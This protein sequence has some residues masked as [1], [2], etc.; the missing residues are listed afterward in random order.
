MSTRS[1]F[2]KNP[3]I[4][5]KKDLSLSSVLQNLQAYNVATGNAPPLQQH[6]PA[7][8]GETICCKRRRDPKPKPKPPPPRRQNR[9]IEEN[10]APM[11]HQDYIDRR[12]QLLISNFNYHSN[13]KEVCTSQNYQELTCDVLGKPGTSKSCLSLVQYDSD[14]STSSECEGKQ[15]LPN[16]GH[17]NESD[18]VK[19]RT[20]QR[21]PNP[22]EPVCVMCGKYGEYICNETDDDICSMECKADLLQALKVVKDPLSNQR[23]DVSSGPKCTLPMHD[24]GDTW[25]YER[26]C[27]SK[28]SSILSTYDCWKCRRPGHLA[29]DCLVMTSDFGPQ[30]SQFNTPRPSCIIQKVKCCKSTCQVT[31]IRD[32]LT[33]QYCFDKAFDKFYDMKGTGLSIISGSI[34][35][36]DHFDWHSMN[37]M[38]ANVE[39]SGYIISRNSQKGKRIQLSDFIF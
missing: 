13:L 32:L 24:F 5:Y 11:S 29:E 34:C 35:C 17:L 30:Q 15:D 8:D 23:P 22:G 36:E 37:C 9:E 38:N 6:M 18:Q 26:H 39:E 19:S 33:C 21:F 7:G 20:E 25:D 14:E 31:D 16:P 28:K 2:Y 12:R 3:S 10:D 27:W 4:S 1:N